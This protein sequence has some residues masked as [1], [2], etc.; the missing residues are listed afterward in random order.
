MNVQ[1]TRNVRKL[2]KNS[3]TLSKG[4]IVILKYELA[5]LNYIKQAKLSPYLSVAFL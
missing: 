4:V 3:I 2:S 5:P 1:Q